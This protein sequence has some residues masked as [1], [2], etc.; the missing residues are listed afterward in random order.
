MNHIRVISYKWR[1]A[2]TRTVALVISYSEFWNHCDYKNVGVKPW[3]ASMGK[4]LRLRKFAWQSEV[5]A[6]SALYFL[7]DDGNFHTFRPVHSCIIALQCSVHNR[8]YALRI[9]RVTACLLA[10][11]VKWR[12]G[13]RTGSM[14]YGT[15]AVSRIFIHSAHKNT[16]TNPRGRV[17]SKLYMYVFIGLK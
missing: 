5:Q 3:H 11:V 13:Q 15:M 12:Q 8:R 14:G 4:I 2:I 16:H 6:F 1:I 7:F 9:A 17:C 10:N